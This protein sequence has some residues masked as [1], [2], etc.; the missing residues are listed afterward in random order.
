MFVIIELCHDGS[1]ENCA[2]RG[3]YDTKEQA[4]QAMREMWE[5]R[6]AHPIW[7]DDRYDDYC[8]CGEDYASL[9][10]KWDGEIHEWHV[11]DTD[12]GFEIIYDEDGKAA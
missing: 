11:Y 12:E 9:G 5:W 6:K 3:A 10:Y 8:E 2:M 1:F 4:S 7:D